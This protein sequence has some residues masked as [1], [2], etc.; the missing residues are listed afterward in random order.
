MIKAMARIRHHLKNH[1]IPHEGN[2][3][4][5]H[6]LR[7]HWLHRYAVGLVML[8]VL[9]LVVVGFYAG[10]AYP[11][12]ITVTNIVRLVN[13]ARRQNNVP[14]LRSNALLMK[15]A[16]SKANDMIRQ[17]YFAHIS[18]SNVSPWYWFKQAG[19]VYSYA[20]ENLAIDFIQSEDVV[21][22]WL[23][24]PAHRKNLLSTR[25]KEVGV[26]TATGT[27]NGVRSLL[28]VQMYGT[29]IV[30][31][32]V[33]TATAPIQTPT[34]EVAK[35]EVAKIP[36]V[37][38]QAVS[39]PPAPP[40]LLTP[41]AGSMVKTKQ[42]TFVG[43][44]EVGSTVELTIDGQLAGAATAGRDGGYSLATVTP[45]GD[46]DHT[47]SVQ[48]LARNLR[49]AA[50]QPQLIKVD[51]IPPSVVDG[52]TFALFSLAAPDTFDVVV[53][54]S[55]DA[56]AVSCAC[57][58]TAT[59]LQKQGPSFVGQIKLAESGSP[60]GG[61]NL[62]TADAAGNE[63]T[64]ALVDPELF[65]VG[66]V[67]A[68]DSPTVTALKLVFYSKTF[69]TVF[70]ILMFI[71]ATLNVVIHMERQHHPTIIGSLLVLYLGGALLMI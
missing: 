33:R 19:Y 3:Y 44:A 22:A 10:P 55:S 9:V 43:S 40:T 39:Q 50:T 7:R 21:Q 2:D 68:T 62:V 11:S 71:L 52:Q 28:V 60:S 4:Q 26:A 53:T 51:T 59:V 8:K 6:A 35:T 63:V 20:G 23:N 64:T 47:V 12:D 34:V 17:Q 56:T 61:L 65:S 38:G 25:F 24:S 18:P 30:K 69:M 16:T 70:L 5:P 67:A 31:P 1:F 46:G 54:A 32:V 45:L 49:S 14:V 27:I 15:A 42:P 36:V 13:N 48:A 66:V 57:G 37:L 29:P 41:D 58:P